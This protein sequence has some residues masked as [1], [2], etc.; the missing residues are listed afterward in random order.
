LLD[1]GVMS[2]ADAVAAIALGVRF[3]MAGAPTSMA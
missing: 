2:G 1:T 3:T